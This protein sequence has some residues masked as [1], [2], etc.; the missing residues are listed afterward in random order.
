MD[1]GAAP[2]AAPRHH[3]RAH[4]P[5]PSA[6]QGQFCT[7]LQQFK[8]A[9]ACVLVCSQRVHVSSQG[10]S[11]LGETWGC[12]SG[13][14]WLHRTNSD[15]R[16][17]P[18]PAQRWFVAPPSALKSTGGEPR[19]WLGRCASEGG[20]TTLR[21]ELREEHVAFTPRQ[22]RL[23]CLRACF[24]ATGRQTDLH[25]VRSGA[26]GAGCA[27]LPLSLTTPSV[28][29]G[30]QTL[31]CRASIPNKMVRIRSARGRYPEHLSQ[32]AQEA[33]H[34][35]PGQCSFAARATG[36]DSAS[37]IPRLGSSGA[38]STSGCRAPADLFFVGGGAPL[39]RP[40]PCS[41]GA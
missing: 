16:G 15:G 33:A 21:V 17:P 23:P 32:S 38:W 3:G 9:A 25:T 6:G 30:R 2:G 39:G 22:P 5:A 4:L 13:L 26:S 18:L 11:A 7:I 34:G 1:R 36:S 20:R 37:M 10:S 35:G 40:V 29:W 31:I 12:A 19:L 28:L 27:G 14:R 8:C 24:Q 41:V